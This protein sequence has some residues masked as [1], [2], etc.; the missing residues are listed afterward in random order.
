MQQAVEG[1]ANRRQKPWKLSRVIW[2]AGEYRI[3]EAGPAIIQLFSKGDTLHQYVCTWAL[4]R[5]GHAAAVEV[6]PSIHKDHPSSLVRRMAGAGLIVLLSGDD[7]N[8]HL[9]QYLEGLPEGIKTAI[10]ENQANTLEALL[11][12]NL[13]QAA[14]GYGWLENLYLI[15]IEQRWLR[16]LFKKDGI[17]GTTAA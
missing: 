15:S 13:Q 2:K 11:T 10:Q 5:S 8:Q 6:L 17:A 16:P 12:E 4:I 3:K 7:R 9:T 1:N 14:S